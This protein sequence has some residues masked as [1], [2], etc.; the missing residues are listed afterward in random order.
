MRA[1]FAAPEHTEP[2]LLSRKLGRVAKCLAFSVVAGTGM[3]LLFGLVTFNILWP[4]FPTLF[5][6]CVFA[7]VMQSEKYFDENTQT[8]ATGVVLILCDIWM[9]L[10]PHSMFAGWWKVGVHGGC[11]AA[12]LIYC[13]TW[14][15]DAL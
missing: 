8:G 10:S 15:R 11:L 14:L 12:G 13:G 1:L 4:Q 2:Q 5:A 6:M 7:V 3:S 9:V